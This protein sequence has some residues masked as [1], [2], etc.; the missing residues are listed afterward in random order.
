MEVLSQFATP[1]QK[2]RWLRPLLDGEIRSALCDDRARRRLLRCDQHRLRIERDGDEYVLN[3]RKWWMLGRAAPA[4]PDP[5]RDGQDEPS[6]APGIPQQ[7]QILVPVGHARRHDPARPARVRLPGPGGPR[8]NRLRRRARAGG[9][10]DRRRGRGLHDRPGAPR[11]GAHPPL[12]ARD[13]RRRARA[14]GDVHACGRAGDV[15]PA[16]RHAREHPGL[17]RRVADRDRDGAPA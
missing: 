15:R 13:R 12:H 7:S 3:G 9:E 6:T 10:P 16:A 8:R 17:D 4:L 2:E 1:A 11:P 14:G 5:D